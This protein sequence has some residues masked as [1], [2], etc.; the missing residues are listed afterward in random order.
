MNEEAFR[1][2][3]I[4]TLRYDNK[5]KEAKA[6]LMP[7]ITRSEINSVPQFAFATR[8]YQHWEDIELRVPV[9]LIN[10][11]NEYEGD[12]SKLFRYVYQETPDYDL[13]DIH[14]KPKIIGTE[15]EDYVENDVVFN[16]IQ[17]TLIQGIRDAKYLIWISVAW[18]SNEVFYN[19]LLKKKQSGLNIR[20]IVSDEESNRNLFPKL[21]KEFDCIK[22]PHFGNWGKNLM[23][24]KFCIVDMEYVMHGS[25]NWTKAANY[26]GETLETSIDRELVKK[27]ADQFIKMYTEGKN[28]DFDW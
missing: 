3:V 16:E 20:I 6:T 11:A 24:H 13:Q 28:T 22:I 8:S 19:E 23:H 9:P 14:I 27:F 26:N 15:E 1:K 5:W 4:E 21:E 12:I 17:D 18:F 2:T 7:I 10:L 25:Y